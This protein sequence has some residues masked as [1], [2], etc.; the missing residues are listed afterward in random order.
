[1]TTCAN[2][3]STALYTY[4]VTADLSINFCE[5]HLPGFLR[6][7]GAPVALV[8]RTEEHAAVLAEAAQKLAP[9]KST[10]TSAKKPL[11]VDAPVEEVVNTGTSDNTES[12]VSTTDGP[13]D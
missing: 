1:M 13:Q 9:K 11:M 10:K 8:Q 5:K 2:C 12:E 4:Q 6:A 7:K 3:A